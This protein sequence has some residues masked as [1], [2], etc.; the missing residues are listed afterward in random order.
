M[1]RKKSV[2]VRMALYKKRGLGEWWKS[3]RAGGLRPR[4]MEPGVLASRAR[5]H[6]GI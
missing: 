5:R 2:K 6:E 1:G 3:A 4:Y